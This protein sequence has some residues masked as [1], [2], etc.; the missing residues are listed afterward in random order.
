[1]FSNKERQFLVERQQGLQTYLEAILKEPLLSCT[2][3]VK[4]FLDPHN[5]SDNFYEVALRNVSMFFRSEPNW[6]VVEPLRN[7]GEFLCLA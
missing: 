2:P 4:R 6:S 1:V 7:I 3:E 5:Y